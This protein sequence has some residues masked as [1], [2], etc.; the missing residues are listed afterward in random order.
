MVTVPVMLC[1]N[2]QNSYL[3]CHNHVPIM[4]H[5][6]P[7]MLQ[8]VACTIRTLLA[9]VPLLHLLSGMNISRD[10]EGSPPPLPPRLNDGG[11]I[12]VCSAPLP[13]PLNDG[14]NITVRSAP[15]PPPLNDGGNITVRSAPL[16]P[17][18]HM[19]PGFEEDYTPPSPVAPPYSPITPVEV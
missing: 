4:C 5:I 9:K 2:A 15:L 12:P 14:G 1:P 16:P 13:P 8:L 18:E 7:F 17:P 19:V 11:N 6:C 10:A 3:S